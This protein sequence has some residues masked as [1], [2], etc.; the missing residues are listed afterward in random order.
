MK[1]T[2]PVTIFL[3]AFL[4]LSGCS[5]RHKDTSSVTQPRV[6]EMSH[7]PV[8]VIITADPPRVELDRDI[9]LTIKITAPSEIDVSLPSLDDRL[10]GFILNG[11]FETEPSSCDGK[12][13]RQCNARLTPILASE[14]RLAPMAI[15]Y[16]DRSRSPAELEW[17][18]T[19]A[20]V[21]EAV[22][23]VEGKA[24]KDIEAVLTP[25][26]IYPAFKTV[27]LYSILV[28]FVIGAVIL[29]WRLL[30]RIQHSMKVRR[31]S[32]RER[33]LDELSALLTKDL[34]A[35]N[36]VKE[37]YMELTMI[38]RRY[39]ERRHLIRAPEQTT[40]EFLATVVD[41]PRFSKDVVEKLKAFL[42]AADLV[43][44][45][46]HRPPAEAVNKAIGTARE[47]IETEVGD[48]GS[49]VRDQK[50]DDGQ[51]TT[52]KGQRNVYIR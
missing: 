26:W 30:R 27:S 40:E 24:G 11:T 20:I 13:T 50:S 45:A 29:A 21:F 12:T 1:K 28:I 14:Y 8:Q 46:A 18:A 32:P 9:L 34:I 10:Q 41:D 31:M 47:Y 44:F 51:R 37:F 52:D 35:K 19:R 39:I 36:L 2:E 5:N 6:E 23:P 22:P 7:G 48:Q 15:L 33:A 25:V 3:A 17:F 43:K 4:V 49:E 38:V 42:E 16:T